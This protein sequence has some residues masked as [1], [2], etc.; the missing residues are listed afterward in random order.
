MKLSLEQVEY[1]AVLARLNLTEAEKQKY[2][3]QISGILDY[4]EKLQSVDTENIVETSQ[5]TGLINVIEEDIIEEFGR[6][7]ELVKCA[8]EHEDGYIK[9]P[10]VLE[11][12]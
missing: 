11:N 8:P 5:V 12:K 6:E 7:Q 1:I 10:K 2:G 3:E 4:V 9:I